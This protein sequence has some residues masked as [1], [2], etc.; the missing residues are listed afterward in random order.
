MKQF[1]AVE[2]RLAAFLAKSGAAFVDL[3]EG[4]KVELG[5]G[6]GLLPCFS[7]LLETTAGRPFSLSASPEVRSSC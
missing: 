5:L 1:R 4:I 3:L 7:L 6:D 2:K